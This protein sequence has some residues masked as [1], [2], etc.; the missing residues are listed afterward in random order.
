[1]TT[2]RR[3]T[4]KA[5]APVASASTNPLLGS[6]V[7]EGDAMDWNA[8]KGQLFFLVM[9]GHY[10]TALDKQLVNYWAAAKT[11]GL[12]RGVYG[13]P[14]PN[15]SVQ[16]QIDAAV[17]SI[18]AIGG[19]KPGDMG[20]YADAENAR[21]WLKL[22][23]TAS[24]TKRKRL[25][26]QKQIIRMWKAS[27]PTVE[28]RKKFLLDYMNGIKA[29]TGV[30][31]GL[32]ASPGFLTEVF[33]SDLSD[34]AEIDLWIAHWNVKTPSVPADWK[35]TKAAPF[36]QLW[37]DLGDAWACPGINGGKKNKADRDWFPGDEAA[38]NAVFGTP[39]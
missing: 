13:F 14:L 10:G 17:A 34:F 3:R 9:R 28:T 20:F 38:F 16:S 35:K 21:A 36:Y 39:S 27:L 2:S 24:V 18:D 19:F 11:I 37:Q 32:Y 22:P 29:K 31:P 4:S 30:M 33:G 12:R 23:R 7:Y 25:Q 15:Q 8:L 26:A 1:M 6:D 5:P